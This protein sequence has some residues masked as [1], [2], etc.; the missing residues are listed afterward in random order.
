MLINRIKI[1]HFLICFGLLLSNT[2]I[3]YGQTFGGNPPSI[4]WKQVNIPAAKVIFPVGMDT[5]AIRIADIIRQMNIATKPT[6]GNQ[7]R[8]VSILLQDQT[9]ISNAYVGLAPFRSEFYLTPDQN[10]FE[11]G[12]LPWAEQLAIHEFRHVQ[13]Y[14]NFN[15]GL[16]KTLR[17]VFGEGG[18]AFGNDLSVP[19]WFF[20]GDAVYNETLVSKQGRGRLPFF[21]NGY[22]A[23]W[24]AGRDYNWMKLRNGSLV[25][26]V[27]DHYPLG[28]MLVAYG[29][30]KYGTMFWKNVTHDA[31]AYDKFFYPFQN[32]VKKHAGIEFNTFKYNALNYFKQ[33]YKSDVAYKTPKSQHFIADQQYPAFVND[34]TLIYLRASYNRLPEFVIK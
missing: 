31:A 34:S 11:I 27:P 7:Q 28:Y 1:L 23:L 6:I 9:I 21:Y 19:N 30:E 33:Q 16:S 5:A 3:A 14:N 24:D 12:S 18:Q 32:A 13:Q 17:T 8:Q 26:Y 20:E 29:R 22:R 2:Y 10:S 4:K 15:V 25:D